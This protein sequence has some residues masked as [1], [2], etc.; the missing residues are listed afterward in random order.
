MVP[1]S[2]YPPGTRC[3]FV[4][5]TAT[6]TEANGRT[7]VSVGYVLYLPKRV[8][9][10]NGD[11]VIWSLDPEGRYKVQEPYTPSNRYNIVTI[12]KDGEA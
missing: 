5:K 9:V 3:R 6:N 7:I 11:V 1:V 4:R 10:K 12:E 8:I 2:I